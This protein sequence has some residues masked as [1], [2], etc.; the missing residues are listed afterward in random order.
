MFHVKHFVGCGN[1]DDGRSYLFYSLLIAGRAGILA[2][3]KKQDR[4]TVLQQRVG[5]SWFA[6]MGACFRL[7]PVMLFSRLVNELST[8]LVSGN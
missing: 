8:G 4:I 2:S 7:C 5:G 1:L 6:A 3:K